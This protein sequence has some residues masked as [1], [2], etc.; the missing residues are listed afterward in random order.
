[1]IP[2]TYIAADLFCGAGGTSTG[3]V[4]A[5]QDLGL[6]VKVIAVNHW[7]VAIA[8]H[9][10]NHPFAD[11]YC[12]AVEA[13]DPRKVVPDGRLRLLVASPECR[14]HSNARGG[15][16]INDQL[17]TSPWDILRWMEALYIE[18]VL[19]ENVPE[20]R[21]WGPLDA[22]GKKIKALKGKT[23][24]QYL[25][26]IRSLGYKVDYRVLTA[27]DYGDPTTRERLFIMCR[28]TR[29]VAWPEPTHTRNPEQARLDGRPTQPW[30]TAREIIDWSVPGASIYTRKRPLADNT[31]RRIE[32]GLR[33]FSGLPFVIGQQSCAAPRSIDEPLPTVATAGA[34][35]CVQPFLIQMNGTSAG[36]L[37]STA[38]S[39]DVPLPTVTGSN[40]FGV[41]QPFV[42]SIRGGNDGYTRGAAIDA[43]LPAVTTVNPMALV[44]PPFF[45]NME[46]TL[47]AAQPP[48]G[49]PFIMA[50]NHGSDIGRVYP[51][52]EPMRTVTTVDAW[53]I[54]QPFLVEYH[55]ATSPTAQRV[56]SV[57]EPLPAVA[58]AN[59]H[60]LVQPYLVKYYG[61]GDG[62]VS[63]DEPLPTVT[64]R[65]RFGLVEPFCFK[66]A[67]QLYILNI[68]FRMLLPRELAAA[69]GFQEGYRFTG[70][71]EDVVKQIGN[72]VP[73][74]L[75]RALC[76]SLLAEP[77]KTSR[78]GKTP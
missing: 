6:L 26:T 56:R 1:M 20:F 11:H 43:P 53:G 68:L 12:E 52:D 15:R 8:T 36:Q 23:F 75:A 65:D 45:V 31:L 5:A 14:Y 70:K 61:A 73:R 39:A 13:L 34:I 30:R 58:T 22:D 38:L 74:N 9:M 41:I 40:H 66:I 42:L 7:D 59:Q 2:E 44:Q 18:D 24:L 78:Q 48:A 29:R 67:D 46:H 37:D 49:A 4:E 32:A 51:L 27:A 25:R 28:R 76:R 63:V 19:I 50:T 57:D 10:A 77:G 55:G 60:G 71:R 3:L 47:S 35:A 33:K 69:Q 62:A 17:R 72:A 54:A 21:D 16:A 64:T